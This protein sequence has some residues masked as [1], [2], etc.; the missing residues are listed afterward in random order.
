[1][2]TRRQSGSCVLT[3]VVFAIQM[4]SVTFVHPPAG[5]LLL[6]AV[7]IEI[8]VVIVEG[9]ELHAVVGREE[10][11]TGVVTKA[12]ATESVSSIAAKVIGV[13]QTVLVGL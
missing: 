5:A 3:S 7:L 12:K 2:S 4:C 8:V 10:L 6:S 13:C 9:A 1:M 11:V